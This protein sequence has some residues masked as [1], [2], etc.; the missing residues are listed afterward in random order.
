[1][2]RP[3]ILRKPTLAY[4][5]GRAMLSIGGFLVVLSVV[6][7]AAKRIINIVRARVPQ[8][9]VERLSEEAQ[10]MMFPVTPESVFTVLLAGGVAG[11]GIYM[12]VGREP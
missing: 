10:T 4:A 8:P 1:M 11:I 5:L 12:A 7:W 9:P 6:G 3:F 2:L